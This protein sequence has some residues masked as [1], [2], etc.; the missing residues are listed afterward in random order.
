MDAL[1]I[2][3]LITNDLEFVKMMSDK[4]NF[5]VASWYARL[6]SQETHEEWIARR[7]QLSLHSNE[8]RGIML[9]SNSVNIVYTIPLQLSQEKPVT[10]SI[11]KNGVEETTTT[12]YDK[13]YQTL[14][15]LAQLSCN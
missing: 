6:S 4:Y 9:C 11:K 10:L 7:V 1:D 12:T 5:N 3:S 2:R 13:L 8:V 14:E 15:N